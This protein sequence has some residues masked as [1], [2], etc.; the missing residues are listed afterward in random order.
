MRRPI[1]LLGI[2]FFIIAEA[3]CWMIMLFRWLGGVG[4]ERIGVNW[5]RPY[6]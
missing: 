2:P 3:C 4:T 5:K 6:L 1:A